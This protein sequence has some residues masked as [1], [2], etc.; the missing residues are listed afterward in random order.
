MVV[1]ISSGHDLALE[2]HLD[3]GAFTWADRLQDLIA[4][5]S[6]GQLHCELSGTF[7]LAL[8][9]QVLKL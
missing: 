9:P 2:L 5:L 1:A 7:G 8:D 4:I 3:S 6:G